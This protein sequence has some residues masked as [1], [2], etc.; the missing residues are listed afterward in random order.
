MKKIFIGA[1]MLLM[2]MG[3]VSAAHAYDNQ[4][5]ML[6]DMGGKTEVVQLRLGSKRVVTIDHRGDPGSDAA[7]LIEGNTFSKG[8]ITYNA[9]DFVLS[10]INP[11]GTGAMVFFGESVDRTGKN[12]WKGV[13][14]LLTKDGHSYS[15]P[16]QVK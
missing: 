5:K 11:D 13:V 6:M 2:V 12:G 4:Y 15:Y 9:S 1:A 16:A 3:S 10:F 7:Y 14:M 8:N